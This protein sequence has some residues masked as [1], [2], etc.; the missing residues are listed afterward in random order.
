MPL[1]I[2][3]ITCTRNSAAYLAQTIESVRRQEYPHFEHIF[4]DGGSTDDT[5][6]MIRQLGPKVT[7]VTNVGDGISAAM[8]AGIR[9]ATG[10]VVAHLHSDDYYLGTRIFSTVAA[11]M[12]ETGR[13]WLFGRIMI[14]R[15]GT[16]ESEE[17]ASP[18]YSY[19][20][21]LRRNFI[22]H[23]ATFVRRC[24]LERAGLFDERIRYTMDYDMWLRLGRLSE[25]LQLDAPLAA[26]RAHAG[27]LSTANRPAALRED[28]RVRRRYIGRS[29][30]AHAYHAVRF[31]VR[32]VR[33][34]RRFALRGK[35]CP[36]R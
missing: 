14:D 19:R 25:P 30:L 24:L 23:P 6:L 3:V 27:S 9:S 17:S 10:D 16:L 7:L 31:V 32:C 1:K 11:A 35:W 26:F 28:Y 22:P 33:E 29:P 8:N 5:L 15:D 4:V 2:S 21:L 20:W 36:A 34:R 13:D 12:A 18:R